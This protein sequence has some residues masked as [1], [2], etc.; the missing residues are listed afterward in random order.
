MLRN[1]ITLTVLVWLGH[2]TASD[3]P[4]KL[5]HREG[6]RLVF[7]SWREVSVERDGERKKGSFGWRFTPQGGSAWLLRGELAPSG[8]PGT[9]AKILIDV[10]ANPMRI[11]FIAVK[12]RK[13]DRVVPCIFKVENGLLVLVEP[14][15]SAKYRADG[16]YAIRPSG[17]KADKKT[18]YTKKS[19]KPCEY[20]DQ[21]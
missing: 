13:E 9:E 6:E 12:D 18:K 1:L 5:S 3:E 17:F 8:D 7:Q 21:D 11:D 15:G 4:A 19:L 10:Q 2:A 20:L 14:E 16:N